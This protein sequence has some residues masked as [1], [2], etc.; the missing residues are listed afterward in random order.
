MDL[1]SSIGWPV[2]A[3]DPIRAPSSPA[4]TL[5]QFMAHIS[6]NTWNMDSF[7]KSLETRLMGMYIYVWFA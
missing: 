2:K 4:L 7:Y 1:K 3:L 5:V 6:L